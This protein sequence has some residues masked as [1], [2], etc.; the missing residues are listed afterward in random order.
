MH[1]TIVLKER[2]E[3]CKLA[4]LAGYQQAMQDISR[5]FTRKVNDLAEF[6]KAIEQSIRNDESGE[7]GEA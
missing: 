4:Y 3:E 2:T 6:Y 1:K 7:H 5:E